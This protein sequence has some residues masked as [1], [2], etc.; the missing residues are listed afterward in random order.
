MATRQRNQRLE[1]ANQ[2]NFAEFVEWLK[3][4]YRTTNGLNDAWLL[5]YW[6]Q[7]VDS[8]ENMPP[9]DKA[10]STS[11][12]LDWIRFQQWR[13]TR[14]I[15]WQAGLVRANA[16]PSQF[17]T[18]NHA[19]MTRTKSNPVQMGKALDIVANDIY[20][21]WQDAYDGWKQTFQG[22]LA[23]S[24]KHDNYLVAETD[25]QTQGWDATNQI[26]P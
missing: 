7:T 18:Q 10:N 13:A 3:A 17:V 9:P 4:R 19:T 15:A 12:K 6:G 16:R 2:G 23:R 1:S 24:V 14:F 26:P 22:D 21:D 5:S 8:W 20:F 11:Y 25:A